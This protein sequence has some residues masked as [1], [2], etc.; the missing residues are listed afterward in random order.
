MLSRA[1]ERIERSFRM[2]AASAEADPRGILDESSDDEVR[3]IDLI[4]RLYLQ[5]TYEP[6]ECSL[7]HL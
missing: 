7:I 2:R 5:S 6:Q 4:G 3:R 1:F